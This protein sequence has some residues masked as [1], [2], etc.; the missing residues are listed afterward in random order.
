MEIKRRVFSSGD[1]PELS[2]W[3]NM[4]I[5]LIDTDRLPYGFHTM[6]LLILDSEKDNSRTLGCTIFL[7]CL[8][9]EIWYDPLRGQSINARDDPVRTTLSQLQW[10]SFV[11]NH[12]LLNHHH[13]QKDKYLTN[14]NKLRHLPL[15]VMK[16]LYIIPCQSHDGR[17]SLWT[18]C[19]WWRGGLEAV[20]SRLDI[21]VVVMVTIMT[22]TFD[23]DDD[24]E[25]EVW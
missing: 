22:M 13:H 8:R 20:T 2:S 5:R 14:G 9:G 18:F 16:R 19:C 23:N 4:R 24:D 7:C 17:T 10:L 25:S 12:H 1:S 6:A 15:R 21:I 11:Q 3:L